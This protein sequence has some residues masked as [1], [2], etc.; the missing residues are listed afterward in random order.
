[1][2]D[3]HTEEV[4][5]VMDAIAALA[6]IADDAEC[7]R[8]TTALLEGW[9][10]QHA[11]LRQLRQERVLALRE[12]GMTWKEIGDLMGVHF[13]RARQIAQGQRGDKHRPGKAA[14]ET[15]GPPQ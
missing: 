5:R 7:V 3:D 9:P 10:D 4:Q 1:M 2:A 13:T 6:A 8:A 15:D 12:T 14:G 11:R